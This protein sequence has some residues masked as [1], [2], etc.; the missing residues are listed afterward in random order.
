ME[1]IRPHVLVDMSLHPQALAALAARA[2]AT[3]MPPPGG[4]RAEALA[5][6][7]GILAYGPPPVA[8]LE[9][10]PQLR[11]FAVHLAPEPAKTFASDRG[12]TVFESSRLWRTVAEHTLALMLATL[13]SVPA[14][15]AAIRAGRWPHEDLKVPFSGRDVADS[16]V[17]VM[18]AGRIGAHLLRMLGALE[19]RT[20]FTDTVAMPEVERST[21]ARQVSFDELLEASDVLVVLLPLDDST[22][23]TLGAAEL[24]RL[25]PGAVLIN[26]AR[27]PIVDEDAMLDALR[28]GRLAA[29]GLDVHGDEP[30]TAD[31]PL[32]ALDN[33][34]ITPHLG[35]STLECDMELVEHLLHALDAS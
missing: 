4:G 14:A 30:L 17:G 32:L 3:R 9:L 25:R 19:A 28:A 10:A 6:A 12:I 13:R 34:V 29:A 26:T 5:G 18:G 2:D 21:G 16:T 35:G 24:A 33:V 31:H 1:S 8:E 7:H 20:L 27:G 22:R 15:D 23:G 11:A